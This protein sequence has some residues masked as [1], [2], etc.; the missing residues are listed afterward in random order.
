MH[1]VS[2]MSIQQVVANASFASVTKDAL[3]NVTKV[4]SAT[5]H[6]VSTIDDVLYMVHAKTAGMKANA[7]SLEEFNQEIRIAK[8]DAG[9]E[10][11][12][13]IKADNTLDFAAKIAALEAARNMVHPD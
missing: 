13:R 7:E 3:S 4:L 2:I 9:A 10:E 12:K 5:N 8:A 11:I 1:K 6:A